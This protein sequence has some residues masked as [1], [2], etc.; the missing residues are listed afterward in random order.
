M[1]GQM[2]RYGLKHP[3]RAV[4]ALVANPAAVFEKVHDKLVQAREY[5]APAHAYRAAHDWEPHDAFAD[6]NTGP[7]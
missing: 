5:R 6:V 3:A 7:S 4:S 2:L 1:L